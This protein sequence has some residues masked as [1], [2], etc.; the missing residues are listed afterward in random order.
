MHGWKQKD[1]K[2]GLWK[3]PK[4]DSGENSKGT[5]HL[6]RYASGKKKNKKGKKT[7]KR[8]N[9]KGKKSLKRKNKK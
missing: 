8:K 9:K 7:L 5:S 6:S 3:R 4:N 2:S 1:S